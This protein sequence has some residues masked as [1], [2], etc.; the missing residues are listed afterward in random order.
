V[1][2]V[3]N[4]HPLLKAKSLTLEDLADHPLITYDIGFTGRSHIDEAFG[5]Q[6]LAPDIVL[7][8]MDSDVIQQYVA[9]GLGVGIIASMAADYLPVNLHAIPADHLFAPNVTRVAV[10]RGAFMREYAIDFIQQLAPKL[11]LEALAEAVSWRR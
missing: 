9:L 3:P 8:A 5:A 6:G 1:I 7:T 10:R 4:D 2:V 11:K